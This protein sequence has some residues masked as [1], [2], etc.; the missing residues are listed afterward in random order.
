MTAEERATAKQWKMLGSL[1]REFG[2]ASA[3]AL[4]A[5]HLDRTE[6]DV[7]TKGV[8]RGDASK[9]ITAFFIRKRK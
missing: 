7:R 2:V 3:T 9:V 5:L 1:S 6:Q 4:V 8:T